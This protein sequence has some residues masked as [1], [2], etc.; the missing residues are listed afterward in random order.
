MRCRQSLYAPE[1]FGG[2]LRILAAVDFGDGKIVR[3][4]DYWDSSSFDDALY[5]QLRT[6]VDWLPDRPEG[7]SGRDSG[8][9]RTRRGGDGDPRRVRGRR[10]AG[11][12][13]SHAHD[14]VLEDMSPQATRAQRR[15]PETHVG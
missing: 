7:Q 5:A 3:C 11:R 12:G 9:A 14:V 2:E 1:L 13:R 15:C 10:R 6:P 8:C 4:V